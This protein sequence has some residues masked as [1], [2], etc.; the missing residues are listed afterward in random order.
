M[1]AESPP[2]DA[3]RALADALIAVRQEW[4]ASDQ[5]QYSPLHWRMRKAEQAWE[6][7]TNPPHAVLSALSASESERERLDGLT[8]RLH[9]ALTE[10]YA[11]LTSARAERDMAITDNNRIAKELSRLSAENETLVDALA[12]AYP[13]SKWGDRRA[14]RSTT[15]DKT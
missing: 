13:G 12:E 6:H 14:S 4:F 7:A 15:E 2:L 1:S 10:A 11:A 5:V 3:L 8:T 9:A